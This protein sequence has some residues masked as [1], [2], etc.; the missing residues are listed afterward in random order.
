MS[1]RLSTVSSAEFEFATPIFSCLHAVLTSL[2]HMILFS[3]AHSIEILVL[4]TVVVFLDTVLVFIR[5]F[6]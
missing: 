4:S 2:N 6:V 5:L 1:D 3:P